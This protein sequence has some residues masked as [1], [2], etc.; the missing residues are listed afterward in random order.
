MTLDLE[1]LVADYDAAVA[2]A[3][4]LRGKLAAV[5]EELGQKL[6]AG[7]DVDKLRFAYDS[8]VGEIQVI[9]A[10]L[11]EKQLA[12]AAMEKIFDGAITLMQLSNE[13]PFSA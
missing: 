4:R 2:E 8:G 1:R 6:T 9:V 11:V 7:S 12:A 5:V 10:E 3:E 13:V